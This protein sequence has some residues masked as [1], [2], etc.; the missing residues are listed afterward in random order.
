MLQRHGQSCVESYPEQSYRRYEME[1]GNGMDLDI[2]KECFFLCMVG[3]S[4]RKLT[5]TCWIETCHFA[6]IAKVFDYVI[7][8]YVLLYSSKAWPVS[9]SGR[10]T[11]RSELTFCA[12]EFTRN[13][14][15]FAADDDNLLAIEKLL[16]DCT[17]QPSQ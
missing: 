3:I 8:S 2:V 12:E 14:K 17:R 4:V 16:S 7:V 1:H 10:E 13:V 6:E 5:S 9:R 15:S 11:I